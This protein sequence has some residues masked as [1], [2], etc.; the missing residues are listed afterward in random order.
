M[1]WFPIFGEL[2]PPPVP[3]KMESVRNVTSEICPGCPWVL[4]IRYIEIHLIVHRRKSQNSRKPDGFQNTYFG[5]MRAFHKS[6]YDFPSGSTRSPQLVLRA[7]HNLRL[8]SSAALCQQVMSKAGLSTDKIVDQ[9]V[10]VNCGRRALGLFNQKTRI[11]SRLWTLPW[12]LTLRPNVSR[13]RN[14]TYIGPNVSR[15]P[16][17]PTQCKSGSN[18]SERPVRSRALQTPPGPDRTDGSDTRH[19]NCEN[20]LSN[21]SSDFKKA[22]TLPSHGTATWLSIKH[23]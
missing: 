23:A 13:V 19:S 20:F 16:T 4:S 5:T 6:R 3:E 12:Q 1:P 11:F 22:Y 8:F 18:P 17:C 9:D 15:V 7:F 10:A 14:P 2:F 21:F